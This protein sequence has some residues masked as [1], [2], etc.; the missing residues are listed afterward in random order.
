M[1][2]KEILSAF[3][4]YINHEN[5]KDLQLSDDETTLTS[6]DEIIGQLD[7]GIYRFCSDGYT[8]A[9]GR[10]WNAFRRTQLD[11]YSNT[12]ITKD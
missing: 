10:Q 3:P 11:S 12:S 1:K 4:R 5:L 8:E 9:F 7:N 6:G 2:T